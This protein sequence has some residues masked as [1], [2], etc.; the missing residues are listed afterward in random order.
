MYYL[1][2]KA[3]FASA[4]CALALS[5]SLS[6]PA[7]ALYEPGRAGRLVV[8]FAAGGT[9]D[10]VARIIAARLASIVGAPVVVEN[11]A[12]AGARIGTERVRTAPSDGTVLLLTSNAVA[13]LRDFEPV[14]QVATFD[15]AIA[16][17]QQVPIRTF[18]DLRDAAQRRSDGFSFAAPEGTFQHLL[19]SA[20][21]QAAGIRLRAVPFG[22]NAEA[23]NAALA[24][25]TDLV[26][27]NLPELIPLQSAGQIRIL[28][29]SGTGP[30]PLAPGVPTLGDIGLSIDATGWFGLFAPAGIAPDR[31]RQINRF[32]I[33]AI[34]PSEVKN[35]LRSAGVEP[36][37][38]SPEQFAQIQRT[39][40]EFMRNAATQTCKDCPSGECRCKNSCNCSKS[41]CPN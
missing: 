15:V 32:L 24:G 10:R 18:Q 41:C 37:G 35:Q 36:T 22:S 7:S 2:P 33:D 12:G 38:T 29:K 8:P 25:S 23:M 30:S 21:A 5:F 14:M 28:A 13:P 6:V 4:L 20:V 1:Q 3:V 31:L 9:A 17:R 27:A 39:E 16:C 26:V 34:G 11:V 19:G 40:S